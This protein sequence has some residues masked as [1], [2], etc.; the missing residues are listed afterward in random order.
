MHFEQQRHRTVMRH[1]ELVDQLPQV[2][3]VIFAHAPLQLYR[4]PVLALVGPAQFDRGGVLVHLHYPH[5]IGLECVQD[6]PGQQTGAIGGEQ[7]IQRTGDHIVAVV[8]AVDQGGI[9][10]RCPFLDG[11]ESIAL[12]G[13]VL[14][15]HQD[16]L[17][18][19]DVAQGLGQMLLQ[20][21]A[22]EEGI[23]EGNRPQSLPLQ[24]KGLGGRRRVIA[25]DLGAKRVR[26]PPP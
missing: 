2:G 11:I 4:P 3:T 24:P 12:D 21:H 22:R 1:R 9:V 7:A 17:G 19:T 23:E 26:I 10:L 14:Q 18:I 15:Q 20:G 16:G 13:D 8:A 5:G 25:E 6:H